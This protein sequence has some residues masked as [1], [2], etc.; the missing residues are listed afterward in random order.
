MKDKKSLVVLKSPQEQIQRIPVDSVRE[1]VVSLRA[2]YDKEELD[3]LGDSLEE[4]G[5][6]QFIIVK[7]VS[8]GVFELI[9]GSRRLRAAK[10]KNKSEIA[11]FVVND[12]MPVQMIL[13]ALA[14]NLHRTNMT[15][16]E[17]ATAFLRLMTEFELSY[18]EISRGINKPEGYVRGRLQLLSMP[19]AVINM[20][21]DQTLQ[22]GSV[23]SL[24]RLPT[25]TAQI[26]IARFAVKHGL[27]LS[28]IATKVQEELDEAPIHRKRRE[29]TPIKLKAKIT[30][31][32][33]FLKRV[34]KVMSIGS[35][36]SEERKSV[37]SALVNVENEIRSLRESITS[38][39]I[40]MI[41]HRS[42][43]LPEGY[44]HGEQWTTNEIRLINSKDRPSDNA[45]AKQLGRSIAA[46][47]SMRSV[48]SE[49]RQEA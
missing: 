27:N 15:P 2:S 18:E 21:A 35:M 40:L 20:V 25:G 13:M 22:A 10:A 12:V 36:N 33:H 3:S 41:P 17:E 38:S 48:T 30:Q 28:E 37:A 47:R 46:I 8:V 5:Q 26:R 44:N 14:E 32:T 24:A 39:G 1:T 45:L 31:W 16:F 4:Q 29:M 42:T 7:Q 43:S 6:L 11:A 34:T 49:K 23:R 19:D 9:I